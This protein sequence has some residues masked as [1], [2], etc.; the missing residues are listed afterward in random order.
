AKAIVFVATKRGCQQLERS[1]RGRLPLAVSAIHGDKAQRE[2]EK[3]LQS[4]RDDHTQ[5]LLATDVAGRGIDV[6]DVKLVVNF[7]LPR[8]TEDYIHRIGRTGRN[9]K[10]VAVSLITEADHDGMAM[11]AKVIKDSGAQMPQE[12]ARRC[13][14]IFRG[15]DPR[16]H[17]REPFKGLEKNKY[18]K[19]RSMPSA[20]EVSPSNKS[21]FRGST[22]T[23]EEE[24]RFKKISELSSDMQKYAEALWKD[25]ELFQK[26]PGYKQTTVT[27]FANGTCD[28][29][30]CDQVCFL[31][32]WCHNT[33]LH[34]LD[35]MEIHWPRDMDLEWKD[36]EREEG[37]WWLNKTRGFT[38]VSTGEPPDGCDFQNIKAIQPQMK[39]PKDLELLEKMRKVL[40]Q[41]V[42]RHLARVGPVNSAED[43]IGIE[44]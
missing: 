16:M 31:Y 32:E 27:A 38:G 14:D 43:V 1:L 2:R 36:L 21:L 12:L 3:A 18:D 25:K 5:V 29:P 22:L 10:G 40:E 44:G 41:L 4:F 19:E 7:D 33:E 17:W 9:G 20:P 6:K 13:G 11:V 30:L 24:E 8:S 37:S 23:P 35:L 15:V 42:L 39:N 26:V 28:A 34:E